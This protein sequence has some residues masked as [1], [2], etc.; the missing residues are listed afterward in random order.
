MRPI[1]LVLVAAI[2]AGGAGLIVSIRINGPGALPVTPAGR[3]LAEHAA[4]V[5]VQS[6][7]SAASEGDRIGPVQL[8]DLDGNAQQLPATRGHR[9][10][11]NVWASWCGPCRDE[12][13]LLSGF[14]REQGPNGIVVVGIAQDD[15]APVRSY[16]LRTPINYP[17]LLDD[18]KG[19]AGLRLGNRLGVL[20]YSALIDADGR[21]LRR[22]YGPFASAQALKAWVS[23]PQ[24]GAE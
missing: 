8:T 23:A 10:L 15:A 20:P 11:V 3:W 13:P 21:L 1:L 18:A 14:S 4:P 19:R 17:I 5:Q 6:G 9:V 12:M 2:L 24:G 16:L 22:K 7:V